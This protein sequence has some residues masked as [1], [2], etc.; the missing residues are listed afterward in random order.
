MRSW[1]G[2]SARRTASR[3]PSAPT[4][5]AFSRHGGQGKRSSA[6]RGGGAGQG[7]ESIRAED[8]MIALLVEDSTQVL[9]RVFDSAATLNVRITS[10]DIQEPNLEAGFLHLTGRALRA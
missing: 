10:V 9:P 6:S 1:F 2:S 4:G 8:G 7:V 3:S 5:N